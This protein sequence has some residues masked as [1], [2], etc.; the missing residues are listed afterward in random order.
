MRICNSSL[1][2]PL[3][4]FLPRSPYFCP[5]HSLPPKILISYS[6]VECCVLS[7][8]WNRHQRRNHGAR[9]AAAPLKSGIGGQI[10]LEISVII[11]PGAYELP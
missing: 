9:G 10:P 7:R 11:V 1:F 2:L 3:T 8:S 5:F 6:V 4:C